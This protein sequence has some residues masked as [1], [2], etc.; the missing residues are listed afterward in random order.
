M[1]GWTHWSSVWCPQDA[2]DNAAITVKS[3]NDAL[4]LE[5]S[6][7]VICVMFHTL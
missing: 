1:P 2:F 3:V 4:G 6:K 5:E 7:R